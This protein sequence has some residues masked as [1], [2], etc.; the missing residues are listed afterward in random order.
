M[1]LSTFDLLGLPPEIRFQ[2][3]SY[4]AIPDAPNSCQGLYLS[5]H[6]SKEEVERECVSAF[7][8]YIYA[9]QGPWGP[10]SGLHMLLPYT[11]E[12]IR[13]LEMTVY[14]PMTNACILAQL[15]CV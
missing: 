15:L 5:S 3:Y 7:N 9:K 1:S 10:S 14:T 2:V 13:N 8:K 11:L 4:I 12:G 6:Q